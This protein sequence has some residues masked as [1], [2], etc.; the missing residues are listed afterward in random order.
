MSKQNP[1]APQIHGTEHVN[2]NNDPIPGVAGQ[3]FPVGSIFMA[4]VA[5]NPATLLGYGTWSAF[6]AGRVPV[7]LDA[8][9]VDFDVA[10]ETGGAKTS[11]GVV[12]HTHSVTAYVGTTDGTYG[13][14]DSSS[15]TP[16]TAKTLTAAAP[17]G[18][19]ASIS[20]V[21]PYIVV[22]MWKRTA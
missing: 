21:Q 8:G 6:G 17:V 16:G 10:E 2:G 11:N 20:L 13:T 3:A 12:T 5:D 22:Y 7:G 18:A 15:T 9:D 14:F 19:V 1:A 4:V